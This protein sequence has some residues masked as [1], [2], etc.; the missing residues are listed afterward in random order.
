LT[1]IIFNISTNGI[2]YTNPKEIENVRNMLVTLFTFVNGLIVMPMIS[3]IIYRVKEDEITKD[4]ATKK[5]FVVLVIFAIILFF[6][7][8]YLKNIQQGILNVI[9]ANAVSK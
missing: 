3:K 7:C 9:N 6:E 8:G 5:L 4:Q 1:L 2:N